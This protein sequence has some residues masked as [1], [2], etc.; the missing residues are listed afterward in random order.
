[1]IVQLHA[2]MTGWA[3]PLEQVPDPVF[4]DRMMGDGFAIDP[5]DGVVR[6]PCDATVI[7]V[8][9]TRHSVSLR[10]ANGAELLIHV[11]LETVALAGNGFTAQ[12]RDGET[13][14]LGQPLLLVDLD[15]VALQAKSLIT[16]VTVTS[17]GYAVTVLASEA[18][19]T[20]GD[21]IADVSPVANDVAAADLGE[22]TAHCTIRVPLANGIHARPAARIVAALKPFTAEVT[23]VAHN[24]PANARSIVALLSAGI[25]HD[26]EIAIGAR[27]PDARA[28]IATIAQLIEQGMDEEAH[29]PAAPAAAPTPAVSGDGLLH[30]IRAA[31][32]FALGRVFQFR[33]G[34]VAVPEHGHGVASENAALDT[35]RARLI[36]AADGASGAGAD[37]AAAHRALVD[38]PELLGAAQAQIA[39]GKSAAF[40]WRSAIRGHAE[41]I[42]ATGDRLLIERIADLKDIER[43]VIALLT[44]SDATLP[45]PPRGAIVIADE[46]LPSHF[47]ILASAGI[48]GIGTA[49][50]GPTAHASILAASAGIPML[51]AGGTALLALNDGSEIILDADRGTIDPAP[52]RAAI[53]AGNVRLSERA[54]R[55]AAEAAAALAP[56]VMADGTRIEI[57]ANL[58]NAAEAAHAVTLGAEGCGLLRTEFL[59][60]DR[61]AAPVEAEQRAAYAA[62]AAGLDGR[63]LIVRTLDIGG[64]KPVAY[65]PFPHEENPALGNRGIRFSLDRPDLLAQQFR[66]ILAGVPAA[67]C[68]IM[69]PMIIDGG[70]LAT[71]RAIL[72]EA[73]AALGIATPVPLGVMVETPAAAMLAASL[74]RDADFL[75]IGSNDLTQYALAAD[76]GNPAVAAKVDAFHPAVLHLIARA[77]EGARTHGRWIGVCGGIASDPLAA[78]IL[79]G[80]GVTELSA[81]PAAIPALKAVVR[82]LT[83]ADCRALAERALA[84][85]TA[86]DVHALLEGAA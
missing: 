71:A 45:V 22:D 12:V 80:L 31:P 34:D 48:A 25:R 43:Q 17:D 42:R 30:G 19:V 74:A 72:D 82:H 75:S 84:A 47:A 39:Q 53:D 20:A 21:P 7:A 67:Q 10:L 69:L 38:D 37:I 35:A 16:P 55:V 76:R 57:F 5:L 13:V 68:R 4:A 77:A 2:P 59:F 36:A 27:G 64:D 58:A 85:S 86:A 73:R 18:R 83:M 40:A 23:I 65:L 11:G 63:P 9:P 6:A 46:L 81:T 15:P 66:A 32:G 52:D 26:D 33:P 70:E 51:V 24:R 79:I 60:L 29:A 1:M 41:A 54:Q 50:G 3:L 56:C 14:T 78:P 61:D 8:A 44:G 62:I 49:F 28:A